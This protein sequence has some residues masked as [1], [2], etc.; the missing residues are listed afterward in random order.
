MSLTSLLWLEL[1]IGPLVWFTS[2]CADFA[3]A[4]WAC[5]FHWQPALP[6]ISLIALLI[7]MGAGFIAWKQWHQVGRTTP[8]ELGGDIA[9]TRALASGA[10][11]LNAAMSVVILSQLLIPAI[12]GACE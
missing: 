10:V 9:A 12:L 6:I 5:S 1:W 7:T 4:P 3:L 2:M 11:L 8:G